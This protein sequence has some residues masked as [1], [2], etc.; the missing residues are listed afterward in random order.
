MQSKETINWIWIPL[1]F[2]LLNLATFPMDFPNPAH[3]LQLRCT[4]QLN[5]QSIG[6]QEEHKK[7]YISFLYDSSVSDLNLPIF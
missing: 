6:N 2:S 4:H 3:Y 7:P 1:G 5:I